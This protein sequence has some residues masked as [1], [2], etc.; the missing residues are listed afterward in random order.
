M[1]PKIKHPRLDPKQNPELKALA[2]LVGAFIEYWGFKEVQ[3]RMWCYLYL[4]EE[5]LS[6]LQLGQLLEIS[7]ALVTQSVQVLLEYRVIEKA[8]KGVNG[9]L[10]YRANPNVAEAI[11]SVLSRRESVLLGKIDVAQARV[12]SARRKKSKE[13]APQVNGE[14]LEQVGHWVSLAHLVLEAGIE[15]LRGPRSPFAHPL[16]YRELAEKMAEAL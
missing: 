13:R 8:E 11:S 6:S 9:V 2:K 12:A 16:E 10:R 1:K 3:G 7:P 14:R 15:C 4:L 5:P